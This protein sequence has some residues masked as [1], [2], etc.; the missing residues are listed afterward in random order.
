MKDTIN[1][2]FKEH[3]KTL[4]EGK[5]GLIIMDQA[6]PHLDKKNN[7]VE[8]LIKSYNYDLL[9]LPSNSSDSIQPND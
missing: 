6:A 5:K 8:E 3:A 1:D 9:Y 2:I 4:P 7:S